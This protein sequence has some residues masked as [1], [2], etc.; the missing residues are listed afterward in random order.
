MG[1]S[2]FAGNELKGVLFIVR[3]ISE[4]KDNA[5][6]ENF[7]E[8]VGCGNHLFYCEVPSDDSGWSFFC[9]VCGKNYPAL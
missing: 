6:V 8:C 3:K 1:L 9:A 4:L 5:E 7:F 2:T